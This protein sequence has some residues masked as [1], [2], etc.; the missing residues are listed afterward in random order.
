MPSSS[1][2]ARTSGLTDASECGRI[3]P[4]V[5][6]AACHPRVPWPVRARCRGTPRGGLATLHGY[7]PHPCCTRGLR[8]PAQNAREIRP[9]D[10]RVSRAPSLGSPSEPA[11][12]PRL[13]L[14]G[15]GSDPTVSYRAKRGDGRLSATGAITSMPCRHRHGRF[16]KGTVARR[17][18]T[19]PPTRTGQ[20]AASARH[21]ATSA[22]RG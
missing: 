20:A 11:Q 21:G 7:W 13:G 4:I 22:R 16:D 18:R 2:R 3:D 6:R 12:S 19:G 8:G 5:S 14:V 9:L 15:R 1:S 10:R 17:D